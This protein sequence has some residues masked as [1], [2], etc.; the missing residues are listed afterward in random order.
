MVRHVVFFKFK[1]WHCRGVLFL[2]LNK[3]LKSTIRKLKSTI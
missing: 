3:N 1:I 2:I